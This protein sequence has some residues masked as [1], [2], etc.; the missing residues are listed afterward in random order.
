V[1]YTIVTDETPEMNYFRKRRE[2]LIGLGFQYDLR[3]SEYGEEGI[4]D[5]MQEEPDK[6][7]MEE[8]NAKYYQAIPNETEF[9]AK[10]REK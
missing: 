4:G 1:F 10:M 6:A 7:L 2:C 5:I 9:L 3:F 8:V